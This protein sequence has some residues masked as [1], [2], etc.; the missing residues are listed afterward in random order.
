M[1]KSRGNVIDP[2][3]ERLRL[4]P[5]VDTPGRADSEGLRYLLLRSAL[6]SSD[7]SYSPALAKQ[8]INSELVNCLG[9]LLSRITSVSINPNQ[10]IVRINREEAEALFGGSDQDA[11]LLKG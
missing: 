11:E 6:L 8:V 4:V 10:A 7:V 2:F 5:K 1:S 3:S 9:N